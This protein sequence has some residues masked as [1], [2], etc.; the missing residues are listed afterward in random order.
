MADTDEASPERGRSLKLKPQAGQLYPGM[1]KRPVSVSSNSS[2]FRQ[3]RFIEVG[4]FDFG[5]QSQANNPYDTDSRVNLT[6]VTEGDHL[7]IPPQPQSCPVSPVPGKETHASQDNNAEIVV[8]G[9]ASGLTVANRLSEHPTVTVLVL[10]A[11]PADNGEAVIEV[12]QFNFLDGAARLMPQGRA[13]GGGTILNAMLVNRGGQGD[14]NDW[15]A[16]GNP[17]WSWTDMLPYFMRSERYTP[18]YSEDIA[19]QFSIR[20]DPGV[21]GFDGPLNVSYPK[22][23]YNAS[24]NFFDALTE[25]GI[26]TALDPNDGTVA[27]ASF[28]LVNIDPVNMTRSTARKAYYDP[29]VARPNLWVATEQHVTRLIIEGVAGNSNSTLANPGDGSVG[30][31]NSTGVG[32]ALFGV[33]SSTDTTSTGGGAAAALRERTLEKNADGELVEVNAAD[34]TLTINPSSVVITTATPSS[35]ANTEATP[36]QSSGIR[37]LGVEF[38]SDASATRRNVSARR[39]VIVAA[40]SL[41]TVQVLQLSGIGP[42]S[43]LEKYQIPVAI[44]LPGVGQ[45]LQ[46][47]YLV[48]TFYP[49]NNHSHIYPTLLSTNASFNAAAEAEYYANRTGPWTA[50]SP[51]GVAFPSLPDIVNGSTSIADEAE[52]QADDEY[53]V[54]GLDTTVVA[55]YGAQKSALIAALLDRNRAAY[56]IINNNAG[57]LTVA[58]MR[59]FTRGTVQITSSEPF[60][61]PAIDPRYGANPID[62]QVLMAALKFNRRILATPSMLEL[63]PAQFV[64]PVDAN[65]DALMQIVKNGIRTEYHPAGTCAMLPL[66]L[67]GVVSPRLQVYGTRNLRIVDASIFPILPASHLQAVVYGVAEKAA[68][69]IKADWTARSSTS[70]PLASASA[71]MYSSSASLMTSTSTSTTVSME[72]SAPTRSIV[73]VLSA[74]ASTLETLVKSGA[75]PTSTPLVLPSIIPNANATTVDAEMHQGVVAFIT[76]LIQLLHRH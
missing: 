71:Q 64:P 40:G 39:E 7:D 24:V 33:G 31:G 48:G 10:E 53:L 5:G 32:G 14:Y 28:L 38:A 36:A 50:G 52:K 74:S 73:S 58:T 21:H 47:H 67:G 15:E 41:H 72:S 23:F 66:G 70:I 42:R 44:D 37:I 76:W 55:G 9:G 63:Q 22:Y 6:H 19:A 62:L 11:G 46:D 51:D 49:Y 54:P 60:Q 26:P 16:L 30:S 59:P 29:Y 57:S 27:G 8:G 3:S 68:D 56:E 61:P 12:P 43:L 35:T 17:G 20:Y 13:L 1:I 45:N 69:I 34:V 75:V 25:L 18:V 65:D 4:E 2:G